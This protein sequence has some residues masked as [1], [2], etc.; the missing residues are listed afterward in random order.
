MFRNM[1]TIDRLARALV[2]APL[3]V[4]GAFVAGPLTIGGVACSPSPP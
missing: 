3:A 2:V 1:G 4:I